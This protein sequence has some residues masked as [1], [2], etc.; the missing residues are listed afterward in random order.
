MDDQKTNALPP[1]SWKSQEHGRRQKS[2]EWFWL[3]ASGALAIIIICILTGNILLAVFTGISALV[4]IL[5]GGQKPKKID[6]ALTEKGIKID[7]RLYPYE[8]LSS[9]CI[10]YEL[11]HKKELVVTT[12]RKIDPIIKIPLGD[13]HPERMRSF[14]SKFLKEKKH[15]E[16]LIETVSEV[17]G[18]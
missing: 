8:K 7:S 13:T 10:N 3:I 12:I 15:R 9:F 14:L 1:I 4:I 5:L 18:F 6:F 11:P 16:S 2:A 17:L